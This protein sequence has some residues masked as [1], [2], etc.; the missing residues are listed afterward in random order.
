MAIKKK[1]THSDY[2][3]A[4]RRGSREAELEFH[5]RPVPHS[6]VHKSK[7][8]YDRKKSKAG[9]EDHEWSENPEQAH[10]Q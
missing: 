2:V 4:A 10:L 7:K 6:K 3:K 1:H 9:L 8:I 5:G